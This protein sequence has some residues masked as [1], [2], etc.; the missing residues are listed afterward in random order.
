MSLGRIAL[1]WAVVAAWLLAWMLAEHRLVRAPVRA[2]RHDGWWVVGEA[3]LL[4]LFAALWFGSL[5]TGMSWLVFL[6]LGMLMAWP[7]RTAVAGARVARVLVAGVLL[8][9]VLGS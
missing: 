3:L 7:L 4:A 8:A 1:S 2:R 5:G 6:L 9:R